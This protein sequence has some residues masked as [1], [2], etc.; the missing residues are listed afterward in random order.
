MSQEKEPEVMPQYPGGEKE[1]YRFM[2]MRLKYPVPALKAEKEGL[3]DCT[4]TIGQNGQVGPIQVTE[5]ADPA[6]EAE[7]IRVLR[8]MPAWEPAM[9]DGKP[10]ETHVPFSVLFRFNDSQ[11]GPNPEAQVIVTGYRPDKKTE[12]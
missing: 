8:Q 7:V 1:F 5:S 10:T 2:A 11:P 9:L 3:V 6:L 12:D 4:I